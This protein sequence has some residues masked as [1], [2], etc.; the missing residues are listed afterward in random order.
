MSQKILIVEDDPALLKVLTAKIKS[1]GYVVMA[2][3]DGVQAIKKF[4]SEPPDLVL[5]DIVLPLQSGFTVLEEI[6]IKHKSK[7]PVIILSNLSEPQDIETGKNLGAVDYI[8]KSNLTL[9]AIM[10]K[11]QAALAGGGK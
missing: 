7:V 8:I 9:K 6:K 3:K 1:L 4:T 10:V 2:A 11:V 5:L